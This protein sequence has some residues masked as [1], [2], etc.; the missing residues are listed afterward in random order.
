M[1]LVDGEVVLEPGEL[2]GAIRCEAAVLHEV[3]MR[4]GQRSGDAA[5][6]A[7]R[8][9]GVE[10][11]HDVLEALR[12]AFGRTG[13]RELTAPHDGPS[14]RAHHAA[15]LAALCPG[16]EAVHGGGFFDGRFHGRVDFLVRDDD[17]W[18][19]HEVLRP[20]GTGRESSFRLAACFDGL[21][22]AGV[23]VASQARLVRE[24]GTTTSRDLTAV[25]PVYRRWRARLE[26]HVDELLAGPAVGPRAWVWAC[27]RCPTCRAP[28]ETG[29]V[30]RG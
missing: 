3:E 7:G 21:A 30:P 29:G 13:V 22:R 6:H 27:G 11:A 12:G 20:G 2:A 14:L 1:F 28:V 10:P 15:T 8:S 23:P 19:A 5:A 18:V 24:D 16:V 17:T 25:V 26:T 4:L 9:D